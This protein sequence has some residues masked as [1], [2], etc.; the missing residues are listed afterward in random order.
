LEYQ[1]GHFIGDYIVEK[2]SPT[3]SVDGSTHTIIEVDRR[4]MPNM[5]D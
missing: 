5:K 2:Y 3:L 4:R 1:L